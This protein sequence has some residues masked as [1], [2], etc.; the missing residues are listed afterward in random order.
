MGLYLL[1]RTI[2]TVFYVMELVILADCI[3]SWLVMGGN[4]T[5][6]KIYSII[7]KIAFPILAPCRALLQ[8]LNLRGPIDFSPVLA[9]ILLSVIRR[10]VMRFLE[11]I[12]IGGIL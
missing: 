5:V 3:L 12:L 10:I 11:L 9:L 1:L 8:R 7:D 4:S 2:G 6:Y